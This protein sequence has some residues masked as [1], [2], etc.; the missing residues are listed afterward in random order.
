[1]PSDSSSSRDYDLLDRL[2]EEFNERFRKGERPSIKEYCDRHPE[3]ADDLRELLPALAEVEQA[4]DG[5]VQ[6]V[7]TATPAA[8][9][10]QHL[11]DF[12]ILREV[13]QGGMGVVYEAEQISLGRR[14]ALK[15]LTDRLM[16]DEKHKRRFEREARAAA[17][18]HHTNIVP[19]FGTGEAEGVP[20]Y[21]MQFI[22]GMG[23]DLVVDELARMSG[24]AG[25]LASAPATPA[26]ECALSAQRVA[27]SLMTGEFPGDHEVDE[28][29]ITQAHALQQASPGPVPAVHSFLLL[30]DG[31]LDSQQASP[32]PALAVHVAP[33]SGRA[34]DTSGNTSSVTLPGQ[35]PSTD[36]KGRKLSYWQSVARVGVQ[37]ADALEYAH[38]Q[39]VVHRDV[40]PSNLLL[41]LAG[42]VWVTDFGLAKAEGGEN[43][44]GT[45]DILGTL[46]YMAPERFAGQSDPRSDVYALGL[47]LYELLTLRPAFDDSDKMRLIDRLVNDVPPALRKLGPRIPRDLETIVHKAIDR[48]PD[49]RYQTAG[50]MRDD[51]QRFVDD[52]PIRARRQTLTER[53]ARWARRHPG[54]AVLG[55]V[56]TAVLV[57]ATVT[58]LIVAGRMSALAKSEAQAAEDEREARQEAE[59]GKEREARLRQHAEDGKAREAKLREQAE[60]N[61][62]RAQAAVDDYFTHVSENRLLQV[63]GLK[64][65]RK[66]LLLS[67]LEFYQDFLKDRANDPTV[68]AG[69]AGAYLRVGK[70][71]SELKQAKE[72][73]P[74]F[75]Q[76]Y[77]LYGELLQA[78][79]TDVESL[80]GLAS[81]HYALGRH[82]E[83]AAIWEKIV[84]PDAPRFQRELA[85][86]Y[87]ELAL[88]QMN[89]AKNID[90]ALEY[91]G[92]ALTVQERL[93]ELVPNDPDYHGDL[94]ATQNNIAVVVDRQGRTAEA[95]R[96]FRQ[97]AVNSEEAY[98]LRP[99]NTLLAEWVAIQHRNVARLE[100]KLGNADAAVISYRRAVEVR[101]RMVRDNPP[102]QSLR[103]EYI[104]DSMGLVALL[105]K[106]KKRGE[107]LKTI[108][109]TLE[110]LENVRDDNPDHLIGLARLQVLH[111]DVLKDGKADLSQAEQAERRQALDGAAAAIKRAVSADDRCALRISTMPQLKILLE[112]ADIKDLIAKAAERAR[113]EAANPLAGDRRK[114]AAA[115]ADLEAKE[116]LARADPSNR[117]LRVDRAAAH[118]AVG[119]IQ[120]NLN[121]LDEARLSLEKALALWQDLTREQP[122]T[123][124]AGIN[125]GIVQMALADLHYRADRLV[126]WRRLSRQGI[127]SLEEVARRAP[128]PAL[129]KQ[130]GTAHRSLADRHAELGLWTE[131]AAELRLADASIGHDSRDYSSFFVYGPTF[132]LA[133]DQDAYRQCAK[134]ALRRAASTDDQVLAHRLLYLISL[135]PDAPGDVEQRNRLGAI[136][137]KESTVAGF[138][139]WGYLSRGAAAYR[140]QD[141]AQTVELLTKSLACKPT[142]FDRAVAGFF[143]AL[144]LNGLGRFDEAK[145]ALGSAAQH[146]DNLTRNVLASGRFRCPYGLDVLTWGLYLNPYREAMKVVLGRTEP[147]GPYLRLLRGQSYARLGEKALAEAELAA[148][149]AARPNDPDMFALRARIYA[150]LGWKGLAAADIARSKELADRLIAGTFP[151]ENSEMAGGLAN[152]LL[153]QTD[154]PGTILKPTGLK[155]EVDAKLAVQPDGSI[156]ASGLIP[157]PAKDVYTVEAEV[158]PGSFTWLRLEALSDP[159]LPRNGPGRAD[160]GNFALSEI[161]LRAWDPDRK[162]PI[163]LVP[164]VRAGASYVSWNSAQTGGVGAAID[165]RAETFWDALLRPG[166]AHTAWFETAKPVGGAGRMRLI[167]RLEF[168]TGHPY[169]TLGRFRLSLLKATPVRLAAADRLGATNLDSFGGYTRL[170][171]VLA[172]GGD[173]SELAARMFDRALQSEKTPEKL[174]AVRKAAVHDTVVF[175]ELLKLRP[176]DVD[177]WKARGRHLAA[178]R[179]RTEAAN[180]LARDR[181]KLAAAQAD[182]EA[183]EKLTRADP[184]NRRLRVDRAAAH[185]AVGLIQSNLN[186]L[187]EARLSLEKALALWE[188]LAK[189]QRDDVQAGID[190]GTVQMA[191][192]DL[193][194][195]ADRLVEWRRLSRLG[196]ALLHEAARRAPSPALDKQLG[197]AHLSLADRYAELGLWGESATELRLA[198]TR[199]AYDTPHPRGYRP[200]P[201]LFLTA[202]RMFLLAGDQ[203]GYRKCAR[204]GLRLEGG[205]ID[206]VQAHR[207]LGLLAVSPDGPGDAK[208]RDRL[209]DVATK[210]VTDQEYVFWGY[211][212][213][214]AADYRAGKFADALHRLT[215]SLRHSSPD[216]FGRLGAAAHPFL[217]MALNRLGRLDEARAALIRTTR[218]MD[219]WTRIAA[220]SGR[221][222]NHL[223]WGDYLNSYWE[224]SK[225]VLGQ[226]DP[227]GPYLRLLRGRSYAR[228]GEKALAQ[229]EFAAAV[230]AR[231]NDPDVWALRTRIYSALGQKDLATADLAKSKELAGKLLAGTIAI[232]SV[233]TAGRLADIIAEEDVPG[234]VLKPIEV[235]SDADAKLTVQPDHSVLASGHNPKKDIYTVEAEVGPGVYTWLCLEALSDP[236]LPRNGPGRSDSANFALSGVSIEVAPADGKGPAASVPVLRVGA[237][238]APRQ[239]GVGAAI[240]GTAEAFWEIWPEVGQAH[241]AWFELAKPVGGPGRTRV[242]IRLDFQSRHERHVLGRFR[243]SLLSAAPVRLTAADRLGAASLNSF[244]GF[245]RLAAVLAAGGGHAEPAARMFDRALQSEKTPEKLLAVRKAAVHDTAVFDELIK[246]HPKDAEL[247]TARGRHLQVAGKKKEAEEAFAQAAKLSGK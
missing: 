44:T 75:E 54:I 37:V 39:G 4:K 109:E 137:M 124:Q 78:R 107:A 226:T 185:Q 160:N 188:A 211:L 221:I 171:A 81:C 173:H 227:H 204:E 71:R 186:Q 70:I 192:A 24:G 244:G 197:A 19:V 128:S 98:R 7:R 11:G 2:V 129:D 240:G 175:D 79:P 168:Q 101:R 47:T 134:E 207:L 167:I 154:G 242:T 10:L 184:S 52:E 40:K 105:R 152:I 233:E 130:L 141:Y 114:L 165:G 116:K 77:R 104:T 170:A 92:K 210:G 60:A 215:E 127:A 66:E 121:Q 108:R 241:T 1:M 162:G 149:V 97:A 87:N 83:A 214:G 232:D 195:R 32:T 189:E 29:G 182:L 223:G 82:A 85:G 50:E 110:V 155:S 28:P 8:P 62:A 56:L 57:L 25:V 111:S 194:Y 89:K 69:L 131:T 15:V 45:G 235:K 196:I 159:T 219:Y 74:A 26:A 51:L 125:L 217:A 193:H 46:R 94:S 18:L 228:L 234:T 63:P 58:S 147:Y 34:S 135:S 73:R 59:E 143:L 88:Y 218:Q 158:G 145:A 180:P 238:F 12:R 65:L 43:L 177:L 41:D 247:W 229:A 139:F 30:P 72:A 208:Q 64:D 225:V 150:D 68:R 95:L 61:F 140:A 230:A 49:G 90:R 220:V 38:K 3:L 245:A 119:L 112:R 178:E 151:I 27:R 102:Q 123:V 156:L 239:I 243:L 174:L 31:D 183:K 202:G 133:G 231:P 148:A 67:A 166:E 53:Y 22:Q 198:L 237:S 181:R 118:Q 20:Y 96:L 33:E 117:R 17:R 216:D 206:P 136:A 13:G 106:H 132:L 236:T 191:L 187:D 120:I 161:S 86:A 23:L 199:I 103:A 115:Q 224:A 9:A 190:L 157:N 209:A 144:A 138:A 142:D 6:E 205:T 42:T 153:A 176:K 163:A 99:A 35:K 172:A 122:N 55:A 5:L 100:S 16:R 113:T 36:G 213:W 201:F 80:H 179:A 169:H 246:L 14:V 84:K 21:V 164:F 212:H 200:P 93:L 76:A 203:D 48:D 146:V 222:D 126:E 91:H